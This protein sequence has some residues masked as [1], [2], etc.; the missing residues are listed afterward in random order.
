MSNFSKNISLMAM[1]VGGSQAIGLFASPIISRLFTPDDFGVAAVFLSVVTIAAIPSTLRLEHAVALPGTDRE[2]F[3]VIYASLQAMCVSFFLIILTLYIGQS[4][5]PSLIERSRL[6]G[7]IVFLPPAILLTGL[8]QLLVAW[9]AREKKFIAIGKANFWQSIV[10][11]STRIACGVSVGSSALVLVITQMIGG[12][13]KVAIVGRS[14]VTMQDLKRLYLYRQSFRKVVSEYHQFP[15]Y[16]VPTG[17][18]RSFNE[19]MPILLLAALFEPVSV[20][21]FAMASRLIKLPIQV[22]GEPIRLAYLQKASEL[23]N[24]SVSLNKSLGKLTLA[25]VFMSL[26]MI[27]PLALYGEELFEMVLGH[28]W[29]KAGIYGSIVSPWFASIFIQLPSA[30]VYIVYKKQNQLLVFQSLATV[31]MLICGGVVF[32]SGMTIMQA[33]ALI[34]CVGTLL[35]LTIIWNAFLIGKKESR[36]K[37]DNLGG[38]I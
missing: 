4:A 12:V 3:G 13:N 18:M 25:L 30:C 38:S 31:S 28:S 27:V 1:G 11:V 14:I 7:F 22:V 17:L 19:N 20:G 34:S 9:A 29:A 15:L 10:I 36:V 21:L 33:L 5:F 23:A 32:Y 2:A 26:L 16:S 35:N 37:A 24:T 8:V 6:G